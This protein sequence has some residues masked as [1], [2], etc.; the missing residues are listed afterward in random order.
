MFFSDPR[1]PSGRAYTTGQTDADG[2]QVINASAGALP[3]PAPPAASSRYQAAVSTASPM[4]AGSTPKTQPGV[5][6]T[7]DAIMQG[8]V[9]SASHGS[10]LM[11]VD[12]E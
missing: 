11:D 12:D 4:Y 3:A 9:M 10:G 6:L 8:L 1:S 7:A 5:V 2:V